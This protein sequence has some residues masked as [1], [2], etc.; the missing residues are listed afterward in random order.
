MTSTIQEV[1]RR[2]GLTEP[3]LRYYE[4]IGLIPAVDRDPGSGHRRYSSAQAE[5]LE[6]L[7]CLRDAGMRIEDMRRYLALRQVR[8]PQAA[9]EQAELFRAHAER[10]AGEIERMRVRLEYLRAKADMWQA[11]ADSDSDAEQA[12]TS[13]VLDAASRFGENPRE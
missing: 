1:A 10:M 9:A 6:S 11:R 13:R 7:A 2:T 8:T 4:Q 5:T 3:T 12:A